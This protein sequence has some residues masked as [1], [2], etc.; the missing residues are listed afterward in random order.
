MNNAQ[1]GKPGVSIVAG[2]RLGIGSIGTMSVK[3]PE[4]ACNQAQYL[5]SVSAYLHGEAQA[6]RVICSRAA[7]A[8]HHIATVPAHLCKNGHPVVQAKATLQPCVITC[9]D[10]LKATEGHLPASAQANGAAY[11]LTSRQEMIQVKPLNCHNSP[12]QVS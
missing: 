7:I 8:Q 2:R 10:F 6:L 12:A 11:K 9:Q 1:C 5:M 3:H 4:H